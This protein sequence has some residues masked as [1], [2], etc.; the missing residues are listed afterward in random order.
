MP[1]QAQRIDDL[2]RGDHYHLTPDDHVLFLRERTSEGYQASDT[3]QLISNLKIEPKF[4]N[5]TRW[6]Y[7]T[8]AI[9]RCA[10]ELVEALEA[11]G[12]RQVTLVPVPPSAARGAPEYDDRML[13]VLVEANRIL[14]PGPAL[15]IREI[16]V[17]RNA[18]RAA[19]ANPGNRPGID[20]LCANYEIID[21]L[22]VPL[23]TLIVIVDDVLTA[24]NHFKAM[25]RKLIER[26]PQARTI[27]VFIARQKRDPAV[28]FGIFTFDL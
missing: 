8:Q 27:G 15:D 20:E 6:Y 1:I 9:A 2:T 23:P 24:G 28:D 13:E 21:E 10:R 16:V 19:H 26:F 7:K 12:L 17:Q 5:T 14:P 18:I 25:Q 22:T 4:R 3:N 11:P